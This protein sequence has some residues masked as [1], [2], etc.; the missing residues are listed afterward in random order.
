MSDSLLKVKGRVFYWVGAYSTR[1]IP[2]RAGF[3]W[4]GGDRCGP[5]CVACAEDVGRVWW[6]T[7]AAVAGRLRAYADD[8]TAKLIEAKRTEQEKQRADGLLSMQNSVFVWY[9]GYETRNTPKS[10]GFRWHAGDRCGPG[11]PACKAGI[12]RA[13]WT[14]DAAVASRL[15]EYADDAARTALAATEKQIEASR[16][17]DADVD[18]PAPAGRQ[19]LPFQRAG[20]SYLLAHPKALLG[21]EMGL[22]KTVQVLGL[23]NADE[24][25]RRVLVICP[26]SLRI[27]WQRE[28]ERWLVRRVDARVV[29]DAAGVAAADGSDAD[30]VMLIT[31]YD[32]LTG[33]RGAALVDAL[34]ARQYDLVAA[35]EAHYC[36]NP[37]AQRT[38]A[39][40]E[41]IVPRGRRVVALTGTPIPNRPIEVQ[42]LLAALDRENWGDFWRFARRYCRATQGAYGWDFS[43]ADNLEELQSR[44]R[45]TLMIRRRKAEVLTELPPKRRQIV[46]VAANGA[47][48]AVAREREA[49]ERHEA[50]LAELRAEVDAAKAAGDE[51]AYRAAVHRLRDHTQ[52]AFTELSRLRHETALAKVPAV[53]DHVRGL[54]DGGADKVVVF[55]HHHDVI[56]AIRDEFGDAAVAVTGETPVAERQAAVDR[57][58][59]DPACQVYVGSITASGV[60]I[61]LTA[62]KICVFAELDWVPGNITQAEDRLHRIGQHDPVLVQHLVIDGS[63]DARMAQVLVAKQDVQD[64]ALDADPTVRA[65]LASE[66][67]VPVAGGEAP[68]PRRFPAATDEQRQAAARVVQALAGVCDG[69]YARDDVGFNKYDAALGHKIAAA[70]AK[71]TLTDG[72]VFVTA[73]FA[74]RYR[75]QLIASGLA[76]EVELLAGAREE[77]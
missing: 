14:A 76:A 2:G 35:D 7:D 24:K 48:E 30:V 55:A 39:V 54:L 9:G 8:A 67:V 12:G 43:G 53:I 20:I 63:L 11:C 64:R 73:R 52:A 33:E 51:A 61:T 5:G 74:R 68:L 27:N 44:L 70:A 75:K 45:A 3:R 10:A 72:E 22:G 34:A 25:I 56:A 21:D 13:W 1:R 29:V 15:S 23:I 58:Q 40:L 18:V 66:P 38:R 65:E 46:E 77:V 71:R 32:R 41:R 69:A 62:A 28:A 19:Y 16:A 37:K 42:P 26:A 47:S 6:T 50:E 49:W 57:F 4:H 60:G 17:A 36:K 31:S 59:S